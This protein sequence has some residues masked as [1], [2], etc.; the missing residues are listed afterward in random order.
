M[1]VKW[2]NVLLFHLH[3]RNL[4]LSDNEGCRTNGT[5]SLLTPLMPSESCFHH[6]LRSFLLEMRIRRSM[7]RMRQIRKGMIQRGNDRLV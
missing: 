7:I 5:T 4:Q 6:P 1:N 2:P 3:P